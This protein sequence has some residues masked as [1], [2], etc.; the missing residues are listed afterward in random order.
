MREMQAPPECCTARS[1]AATHCILEYGSGILK[2]RLLFTYGALS[3]ES[4]GL[5]SEHTESHVQATHDGEALAEANH[6]SIG[7]H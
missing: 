3:N 6:Q 5:G 7:G 2:K 4:W 1:G